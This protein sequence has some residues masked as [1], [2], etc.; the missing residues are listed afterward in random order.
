[1]NDGQM[2]VARS[3]SERCCS[4]ALAGQAGWTI[5]GGGLQM[6]GSGAG[7]TANVAGTRREVLAPAAVDGFGYGVAVIVKRDA[8]TLDFTS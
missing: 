7:L 1:M 6:P 8:G 3:Q 4:Q 2:Q 5:F